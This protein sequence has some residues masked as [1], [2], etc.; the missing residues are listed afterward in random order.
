MKLRISD[1]QAVILERL[2]DC[3]DTPTGEQAALMSADL[4]S[5]EMHDLWTQLTERMAL[6]EIEKEPW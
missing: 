6:Q 1:R 2:L 3:N 5:P 4:R